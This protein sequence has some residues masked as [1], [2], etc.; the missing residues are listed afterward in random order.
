MDTFIL[1]HFDLNFFLWG[2]FTYIYPV[3]DVIG[4]SMAGPFIFCGSN[5]GLVQV[6]AA[7]IATNHYSAS[8][9]ELDYKSS[10]SLVYINIET[11]DPTGSA[12][13]TAKLK[14]T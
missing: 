6:W 10:S 5:I 8:L 13:S 12:T 9:W 2:P 11:Y 7:Q 4:F 14:A 1:Q 3:L